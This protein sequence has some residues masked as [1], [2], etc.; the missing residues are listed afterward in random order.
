MIKINKFE[1]LYYQGLKKKFQMCFKLSRGGNFSQIQFI[2][3]QN[4]GV[5]YWLSSGAD[6]EKINFGLATYA[7]TFTLLDANNASLYANITGGG[8]AGPYTRSEGVLGYNEVRYL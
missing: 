8:T 2:I 4:D 1:A 7:R 3:F 6:P 5:D